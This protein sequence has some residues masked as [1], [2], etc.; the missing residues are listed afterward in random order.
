VAQ[1]RGVEHP[2]QIGDAGE[3]GADLLEMQARFGGDQARDGRLADARRPPQDRRDRAARELGQRTLGAEQVRLADDLGQRRRAQ[4]VGQ[5]ARPRPGR[6][7]RGRVE[8]V[9]AQRTALGADSSAISAS[10][11]RPSRT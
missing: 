8:Q 9:G 11:K 4:A 3:D 7:R 6:G 2:A 10:A 1:P 5:R